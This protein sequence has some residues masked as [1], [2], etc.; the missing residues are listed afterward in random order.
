MLARS[1]RETDRRFTQGCF[2]TMNR[3]TVT[4]LSHLHR[5]Y[6]TANRQAIPFHVHGKYKAIIAKV[7]IDSTSTPGATAYE[8]LRGRL[9]MA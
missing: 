7:D 9:I 2:A 4:V 6:S 5:E 8:I 3:Q 1:L